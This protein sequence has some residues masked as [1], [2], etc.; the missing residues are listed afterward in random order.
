[1]IKKLLQK[2]QAYRDKKF[3]ARLERVLNNNVVGANLFIEKNIY[4]LRGFY[5]RLPKDAMADLLN[6]IPPSL[7]EERIRSGYYEENTR[8]PIPSFDEIIEANKDVLERIKE[9]AAWLKQIY[10]APNPEVDKIIAEL[11]EDVKNNPMPKNMTKDEEI[12][13]ILKEANGEDD[14]EKLQAIISEDVTVQ[15]EKLKESIV[16]HFQEA[17]G[18]SYSFRDILDNLDDDAIQEEIIK[19]ARCNFLRLQIIGEKGEM[20]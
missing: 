6:K 20:Q 8:M 15:T 1:M 16:A 7:V 11:R 14:F 2:Y 10:E 17:C 4:S 9:K 5:M 18:A 19:W 3:L 12:A 13:W